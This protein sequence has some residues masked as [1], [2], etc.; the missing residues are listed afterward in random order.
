MAI[1][2]AAM[3]IHEP[4]KYASSPEDHATY[5]KWR[6]GVLIFYGC[7]GLVMVAAIAVA[8]FAGIAVQIAHK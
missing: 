6:R 4:N 3:R 8:E 5:V 1:S 7:I 2:G